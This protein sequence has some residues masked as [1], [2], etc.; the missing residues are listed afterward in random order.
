MTNFTS[1]SFY[2]LISSKFIIRKTLP[3]VFIY[4][5]VQDYNTGDRFL[6]KLYWQEE[7]KTSQKVLCHWTV[8]FCI[9][10]WCYT[11][12]W[13]KRK[14]NELIYMTSKGEK[15]EF[16]EVWLKTNKV[17]LKY[18]L[19]SQVKKINFWIL[20]RICYVNVLKKKCS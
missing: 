8:F 18:N 12:L 4:T 19:S 15:V 6:K 2:F 11:L 13:W 3:L 7:Q 16:L 14:D 10:L 1:L 20:G 5:N 9:I 17:V